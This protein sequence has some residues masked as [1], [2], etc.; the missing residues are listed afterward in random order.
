VSRTLCLT[1]EHIRRFADAS[2]DRNPL[3]V[4][5]LFARATPYGR[6]I[7]HGALV[8]IA[9]LGSAS[10][11]ALCHATR[12]DIDFREPV[13]P[14]EPY[15]VSCAR[16][17]GK[18]RIEVARA[19]RL[20]AAITVTV[21]LKEPPLPPAPRPAARLDPA[22]PR[23]YSLGD[24][25]EG[26]VSI[27]ERYACRLDL[28]SVLAGE[29]GA[30]T[31]PEAL[32]LWLSAASYTVGMLVPGRDAV[33]ARARI[34]RSAADTSGTL[35]ASVTT[36]D[37]RTGLV[38][39]DAVL[40]GNAASARMGLHT[41]LRPATPVPDRTSIGRWLA[42]SEKLRGRNVVVVGASRG[43]GAALAGA[44]AT[45]EATVWAVF[46]RSRERAENLVREFGPER[47][48]LLQFDAEDIEQSRQAFDRL[49]ADAGA[50]D[51]IVLCAA[52]AHYETALHPDAADAMLRF[53]RSSLAMTLVPLSGALQLLSPEG[54]VVVTSSSAVG[55]PPQAG[56]QVVLAKAALEGAAA[57]CARHT[58]ARV[59]VL[60]PP[61]MWTDRT[62]TPLVRIG[63]T[64]PEQV[65]AAAVTWVTREEGQSRLSL[66][67]PEQ[68]VEEPDSS[69]PT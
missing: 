27:F 57:Y 7:S 9:A 21:D 40:A 64:G 19:E 39:V 47:I 67:T 11:E 65:A 4:D 49:R 18:T 30:G 2:G 46:A 6:C 62:N 52:P 29:L 63:A 48:R 3:H 51:G 22:S 38:V 20:A 24:V 25:T 68:L 14:D 66:L 35:T 37:D 12:L 56:P 69:T 43:L 5:E 44:L 8:S 54:W 61:T 1:K 16:A 28:L 31:V 41:F 50:L 36:A 45:Q 53:L 33:F 55:D 60:R 34:V 42:P 13:F 59:L 15:T 17:G 32:L 10:P 26:D 23:H 58:H